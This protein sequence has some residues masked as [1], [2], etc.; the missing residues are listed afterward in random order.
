MA[1]VAPLLSRIYQ[2]VNAF[3]TTQLAITPYPVVIRCTDPIWATEDVNAL[4]SSIGAVCIKQRGPVA[5]KNPDLEIPGRVAVYRGVN[6]EKE[7][8][9]IVDQAI[10]AAPGNIVVVI[11]GP[12]ASQQGMKYLGKAFLARGI[13]QEA[14]DLEDHQYVP[15]ILL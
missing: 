6:S 14:D 2:L 15:S 9:M 13:T 3:Y 5:P 10:A 4:A 8:L 1:K 11:L 7:A 12:T